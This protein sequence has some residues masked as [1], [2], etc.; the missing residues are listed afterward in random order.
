LVV[1]DPTKLKDAGEAV[2]DGFE[3]VSVTVTIVFGFT[4][5]GAE[6]VRWPV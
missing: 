2:S 6:I 5:P 1:V 3:T 4:A